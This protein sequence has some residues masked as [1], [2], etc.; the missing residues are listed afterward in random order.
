MILTLA[1]LVFAQ[2]GASFDVQ[3]TEPYQLD[4]KVDILVLDGDEFG[5]DDVLNLRIA[6]TKVMCYVSVGTLEDYRRDFAAFPA[7]VIGKGLPDWP[8]ERYLDI[9]RHD[10]LLPL[11]TARF[12]ACKD[13]GFEGIS[14]DN[15]DVYANDSGFEL[16]AA[17]ALSYIYAL[18]D[19]AH[20]MGL[21]IGQKNV[22][23][24][25]DVLA[26]RLDFAV[27]ESCWKWGFC[28]QFHGYTSVG[29]PILDIE[30]TDESPDFA[31]ACLAAREVGISMILKDRELTGAVYEACQ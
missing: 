1:T 12:Q 30:Y 29:K 8:D 14:P 26:G 4:R 2:A 18:A 22:P 11:M 6:G 27:T 28:D 15:I 19:V 7:A 3:Y 21:A 13:A 31:A 16:T 24:L 9:R 25:S 10:I 17:D 20:G 5:P 23:E